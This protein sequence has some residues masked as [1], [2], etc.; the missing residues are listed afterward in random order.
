MFVSGVWN[1]ERLDGNIRAPSIAVMLPP[2]PAPSGG[3][4]NLPDVK[5][6]EKERKFVKEV[7]QPEDIK[8]PDKPTHAVQT[9]VGDGSGEGSGSGSGSA[10][11]TGTCTHDCG[12]GSGSATP[13]PKKDPPKEPEETLVPPNVLTMNWLT[14]TKQIHP[15]DTTKM[16][17]MRDG[18][19]RTTGV[20]KICINESGRVRT[21][22]VMKSTKY[23]TYD[24]QLLTS[25]RDWTYKPFAAKGRNV[26]VCGVVTFVYSIKG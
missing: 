16:Q 14:G 15:S 21:A 26:R 10:R 13:P 4:I 18:N 8:K 17:M 20:V 22:D 6:V 3:P 25:I 5:V 2:M 7:T 12:V 24:T 9:I 23:P 1:I 11:D 19:S